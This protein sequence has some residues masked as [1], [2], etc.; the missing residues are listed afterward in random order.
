MTIILPVVIL[1]GCIIA[2]FPTLADDASVA[3]AAS[4][5]YAMQE[6]S[7]RFQHT[8]S[9][10]IR[11]TLGSSRNLMRQIIQG[12]PFELFL[13]ADEASVECLA[14]RSLTKGDGVVYALGR[15]VVFKPNRSQVQL[16]ADLRF[17]ENAIKDG[18][19]QRLAIANPETAPYGAIALEA[20]RNAG[21]WELAKPYVVT[22]ENALQA[23][24]Y[25][26]SGSADAAIFPLAITSIPVFARRGVFLPVADALYRPL[27]QKMVLLKNSSE[28]ARAFY[29]YLQTPEAK[30]ILTSH[31]F[32]PQEQ[33][34]SRLLTE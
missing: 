34:A 12:A 19:L 32:G 13:S 28:A 9:H 29:Q 10:R 18:Q 26:L 5:T 15:L 22:G 3:A 1:I 24:Q 8:G 11:L 31:G 25:G 27:K 7:D 14:A 17:I 6:L 21:V 4:L 23:A 16:T 33:S 20:L 2:P 30:S